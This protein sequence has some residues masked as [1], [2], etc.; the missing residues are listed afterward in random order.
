MK[1]EEF[2]SEFRAQEPLFG[3]NFESNRKSERNKNLRA[4]GSA[5]KLDKDDISM[6]NE[7]MNAQQFEDPNIITLNSSRAQ[8]MSSARNSDH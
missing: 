6:L 4:S 5:I 8:P 1:T 3:S 7:I 2:L